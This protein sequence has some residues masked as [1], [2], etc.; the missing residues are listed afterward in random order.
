MERAQEHVQ[1]LATDA[2]RMEDAVAILLTMAI[3]LLFE[4]AYINMLSYCKVALTR[5]ILPQVTFHMDHK[6]MLK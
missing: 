6:R 2:K 4:T 1:S 5:F 3:L